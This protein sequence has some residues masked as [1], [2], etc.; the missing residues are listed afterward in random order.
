LDEPVETIDIIGR[1][2]IYIWLNRFCKENNNSV[3]LCTHK[4]D[5]V[6]QYATT[7]L[8]IDDKRCMKG[9]INQKTKNKL[10]NGKLY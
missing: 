10:I 4:I 9:K 8:V 1:K 5:E 3:L 2:K 6:I 7:Y